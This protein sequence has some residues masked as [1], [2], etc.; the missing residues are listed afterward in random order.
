MGTP[1]SLQNMT[2]THPHTLPVD[3]CPVQV[4][5][6][7][8]ISSSRPAGCNK[9]GF[10]GRRQTRKDGVDKGWRYKYK[11][12]TK[13]SNADKE[14][15]QRWEVCRMHAQMPRVQVLA[16]EEKKDQSSEDAFTQEECHSPLPKTSSFDC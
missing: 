10:Q 15:D 14:M 11:K 4:P 3:P 1:F 8:L 5:W 2:V 16:P 7:L 6:L 9:M 13:M 12:N